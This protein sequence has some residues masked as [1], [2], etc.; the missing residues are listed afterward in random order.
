V[1]IVLF[2]LVGA[3]R[4]WAKELLVTFSIILAMFSLTVLEAFLP[5]FKETIQQSQPSTVFWLK[6]GILMALV[7]F[8]YQTPKIPRLAE[9][10]RFIRHVLQDTMLGAVLGG[11]NGYLIFGTV[12]YYLH[13]TGYPYP[14]VLPPDALTQSGQTALRWIENLPPGNDLNCGVFR[15]R[16]HRHREFQHQRSPSRMSGIGGPGPR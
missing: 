8:G 16:R 5:F 2:A 10:E 6:S 12:W 13:S 14:F 15:E 3:M 1:F 7:F 11:I 4:G 9:S